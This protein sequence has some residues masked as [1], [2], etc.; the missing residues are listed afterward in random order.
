MSHSFR[1]VTRIPLPH[2]SLLG[3]LLTFNM[4][5]SCH[6]VTAAPVTYSIDPTRSVLTVSSTLLDGTIT[7]IGQTPNGMKG[8]VSGFLSAERTDSGLTF[9]HGSL[10]DAMLHPEGPFRPAPGSVGSPSTEDNFG[11]MDSD[12]GRQVNVAIR[13]AQVDIHSGSAVFDQPA[14]GL[15]FGFTAGTLDFKTVFANRSGYYSL[16]DDVPP[17]INMPSAPL[18]RS[19]QGDVETINFPVQFTVQFVVFNDNPPDSEFTLEGQIVASAT[20]GP[21][22]DI[23]IPANTSQ[24]VENFR[25]NRL[26]LQ[27]PNSVGTV[28]INGGDSGV[29]SV[30]VL[31]IGPDSKLEL[32]NND[33]IV[34]S[35]T[36]EKN[37]EHSA[38]QAAIVSAQNGLDANFIT[39]WDGPGITSSA[40][41]ATNIG[42]GFDLVG[43][44]AIRNSDIDII[45]G[46]PGASYTTFSG[47]PVTPDDVLVKYTY[48]G[49]GNLDGLVSFDDY[50][51]MDNAFFGLIPN[52]GWAT[53]DIN[54][55]GVINFDDYT[56]VDQAFF[57]QGARL[58]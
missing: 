1:S 34:R 6:D 43:L 29:S 8:F 26:T 51:G 17:G 40:A 42:G 56:V 44:G 38:V 5:Q 36:A 57:F 48:I 22:T 37:T 23:V 33:L 53:G 41:R 14:S 24:S 28:N 55:D 58:I 10:I 18:T 15:L 3:V 19:L 13:D 20:V 11:A 25:I 45:T 50:V 31:G 49:D 12:G 52:L 47:Q 35:T 32:H 46:L 30:D 54:F 7:L 2:I 4:I 27:G 21:A 16:R 9:D 39:K